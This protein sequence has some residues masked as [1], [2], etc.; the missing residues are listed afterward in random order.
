ML[1]TGSSTTLRFAQDESVWV[2]ESNSKNN[3]TT[4][5][6]AFWAAL[7]SMLG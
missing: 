1:R 6:A 7:T 4:V 3:A 2:W 5:K